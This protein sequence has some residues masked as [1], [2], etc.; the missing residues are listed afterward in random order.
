MIIT[1]IKK[2]ED[3]FDGSLIY[4]YQFSKAVDENIMKSLAKKERL[5]YYPYFA[6]P[7]YKIFTR[8]GLQIKGILGEDNLEVTF[9]LTGQVEKKKRFEE[10]LEALLLEY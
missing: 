7:F 5:D 1:K 3:C 2:L 4:S 8:D 9:P 6:K 10:N